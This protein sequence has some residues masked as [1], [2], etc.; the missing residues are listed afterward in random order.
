[1][2]IS[3]TCFSSLSVKSQL[4][5]DRS[6]HLCRVYGE[7]AITERTAQKW[8]LGLFLTD[9]EAFR[10]RN[11]VELKMWLDEFFE[12]SRDDF[13]G[14]GIHKLVKLWQEVVNNAGEY[15]IDWFAKIVHE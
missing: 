2:S 7:D 12:S 9:C 11:Y 5:Q 10:S 1:M 8:F 6:R 3:N 4:Y 15:M 13:Y 14:Q